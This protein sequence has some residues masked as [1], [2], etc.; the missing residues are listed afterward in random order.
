MYFV[1]NQAEKGIYVHY[2]DPTHPGARK[3][4]WEKVKQGYYHMGSNC[5]GWMP[6]N[7]KCFLWLPK[8][9]AYML[10]MEKR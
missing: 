10:A 2:Y 1:D 7:L 6:A 8:T 4:I 3:Y 9:C 5:S